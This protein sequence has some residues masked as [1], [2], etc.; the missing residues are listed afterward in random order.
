MQ[1]ISEMLISQARRYGDQTF[2]IFEDRRW[3][4]AA[5]F[6]DVCRLA[7]VLRDH[8]IEKGDVVAL[9]LPSAPELAIG[10]HACQMLGAIAAPMSSLYRSTEIRQVTQKTNARVLITDA[11]RA[12]FARAVQRETG[13]PQ[14][15]LV[16]GDASAPL[17]T[18]LAS[19]PDTITPVEQA[20]DDVAALFFTSGTTGDPKGAMQSQR[21]IMVA[22]ERSEIYT[23]STAGKETY[24]CVLPLFNNFGATVV[25][26]GAWFN[27]GMI[28][29]QERWDTDQV[30]N[31]IATH[32]VTLFFGTPTMFTFILN[33]YDQNLHDLSSLR[34]CLAG[35]AVLVPSL[36]AA[37]EARIGAR[38]VNVYGSTEVATYVTAEP[39]NGGRMDGS[40]GLP[41][42]DTTI[43]IVDDNGNPV[44]NGAHGE[45]LIGGDTVGPGYWRDP[46]TT[47]AAFPDGRWLSGDIGYVG[48]NDHVFVID[49]KK[50]VI[51][52]GGFNIYPG[53][54]ED[55]LY[56]H[57]G[58]AL[59]ALVGLADDVKGELPVAYIVRAENT[60]PTGAE[61][62]AWCRENLA[63]YKAPRYVVFKDA[64][65]LGPTGKILKKELR[66]MVQKEELER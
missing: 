19:A 34:I 18:L 39:L 20:L 37:F 52:C 1:T 23:A 28:V 41:I 21:N 30:I 22:T 42:G 44:S 50:D 47:A 65:P 49:R 61:L 25:L 10:Y 17:E 59:C 43:D 58:V 33:E 46:E 14:H 9:Y 45:I 32:G 55:V 31:D 4:Y 66:T 26:N 16:H 60:S 29:L 36:V 62:I 15:I 5:Y 64:L 63:A 8:G 57:D 38:L 12:P 24:L 7:N 27:G 40:V 3:T 53:E 48:E 56:S 13:T 54:V 2:L 6:A 35:G 11:E 51:I